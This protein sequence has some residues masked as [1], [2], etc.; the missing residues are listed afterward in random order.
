MVAAIAVFFFVVAVIMGGYYGMSQLPGWLAARRLDRRV[1][2]P[3]FRLS[4]VSDSGAR[5]HLTRPQLDS[6][7][8]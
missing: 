6:A 1:R 4:G 7:Q 3:R 2:P 5:C 8:Q